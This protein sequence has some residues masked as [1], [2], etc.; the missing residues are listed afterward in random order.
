[1]RQAESGFGDLW[2]NTRILIYSN[3]LFRCGFKYPHLKSS[4]CRYRDAHGACF[5]YG[6]K[7][8]EVLNFREVGGKAIP[9]ENIDYKL[10]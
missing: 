10:L 9:K 1:M 7:L 8:P 2:S 5:F 3:I 6:A 4:L